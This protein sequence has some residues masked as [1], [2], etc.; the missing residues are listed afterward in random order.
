MSSHF[1]IILHN[2][3][4]PLSIIRFS[5]SFPFQWIYLTQSLYCTVIFHLPSSISTINPPHPPKQPLSH[6]KSS[7]LQISHA[8]ELQQ[9]HDRV[10]DLQLVSQPVTP[11][12][13]HSLTPSLSA[14]RPQK[15]PR[16]HPPPPPSPPPPLL[17][18]SLSL[19]PVQTVHSGR[20]AVLC[21]IY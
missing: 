19:H 17:S 1:L 2:D 12:L 8:H 3:D 21:L 10:F 20:Q 14:Q 15:T 16:S 11:S 18:L 6:Y 9:L 4:L 5:F 7:R 13:P